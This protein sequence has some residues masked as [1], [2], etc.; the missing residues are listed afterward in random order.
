MRPSYQRMVGS[1]MPA[2]L[3]TYKR[4][5]WIELVDEL[6]KTATDKIRRVKLRG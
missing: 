6:P 3:A 4:P 5:R 2:A 1:I